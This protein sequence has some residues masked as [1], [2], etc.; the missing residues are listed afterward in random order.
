MI[1]FICMPLLGLATSCLFLLKQ[2]KRHIFALSLSACLTLKPVDL[3]PP[4]V[5]N[6]RSFHRGK[7]MPQVPNPEL[8]SVCLPEKKRH[9]G[10]KLRIWWES[11]NQGVNVRIC[12]WCPTGYCNNWGLTVKF[13][14]LCVRVFILFWRCGVF[15]GLF[16]KTK[17]TGPHTA[18]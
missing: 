8:L 10:H 16:Q 3:H 4:T 6:P 14:N 7:N 13:R 1:S 2:A 12:L 9:S 5:K 15:P 17:R 18:Q 11:L